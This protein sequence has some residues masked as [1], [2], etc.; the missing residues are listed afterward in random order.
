MTTAPA[1]VRG[2]LLAALLPE[3]RRW[4][5]GVA[6]FSPRFAGRWPASTTGATRFADSPQRW[7]VAPHVEHQVVEEDASFLAC[8]PSLISPSSAHGFGRTCRSYG[9]TSVT[10]RRIDSGSVMPRASAVLRL[11]T[12]SK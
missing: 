3:A 9:M 4:G 2:L 11:T 8:L 6:R 12:K 10:C 1:C 5:R 7:G